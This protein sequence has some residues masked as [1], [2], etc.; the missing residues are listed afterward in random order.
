VPI[1][2]TEPF[3]ERMLPHPLVL[4]PQPLANFSQT[5][6]TAR[7]QDAA[8]WAETQAMLAATFLLDCPWDEG[9]LARLWAGARSQRP[10][11]TTNLILAALAEPRLRSQLRH[12][13]W[14]DWWV[15]LRGLARR[16][17]L[18]F[19]LRRSRRVHREWWAFLERHTADRWRE[20]PTPGR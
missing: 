15:V 7:S 11:G 17:G 10:T 18:F 12:A 2:V 9:R 4:V 3:R 5:L 13:R 20:S 19:R 8:E 14:S 6:Q 1:A 16:P